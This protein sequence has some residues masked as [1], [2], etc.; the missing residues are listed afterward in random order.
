VCG[1]PPDRGRILREIVAQ[2][3]VELEIDKAGRNRGAL[4][5]DVRSAGRRCNLRRRAAGDDPAAVDQNRAIHDHIIRR[6]KRR[7][8]N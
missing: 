5:V 6:K 3:A 4:R 1:H 8:L 7:T 2:R